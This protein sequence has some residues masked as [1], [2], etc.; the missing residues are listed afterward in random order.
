[1]AGG[2]NAQNLF[3]RA[4]LFNPARIWTDKDDYVPGEDVIL[5]GSGWKANE[6]VYLYAVDDTTA[7]W[8]YGT[9][10]T[11]DASGGFIIDPLFVVEL[12]QAGAS[13]SVSSV[14]AQSAMQADVDFTDSFF[15]SLAVAPATQSTT[16]GTAAN[17]T[18]TITA[19]FNANP[20]GST[21]VGFSIAFTGGTPA[22]V[23][24][25]F[26]P[27]S[28]TQASGAGNQTSTLTINTSAGT[29]AGTYNFTVTGTVTSGNGPNRNASGTLVVQQAPAITSANTTTFT[30]N[31]AGT[32]TATATGV[33]APTFSETGALPS[34][35]TFTSGGVL[36]GTPAFGT[37]GNYLITITASNGVSP[38]A[39]Q[40]FTLLVV[41]FSRRLAI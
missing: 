6:N 11:A 19:N 34:G 16:A 38:N 17:P 29:P 22:G 27:T 39:T 2:K 1:M 40:N 31:S 36:S 13:F 33:P 7:A 20:T 32:F 24:T 9:T 14:G 5:S 21:T 41:R 3:Q 35:V 4:A 15:A 12:V 26:S 28:V 18:Y 37:A 25:T 10:V 30:V 23:T 8:T